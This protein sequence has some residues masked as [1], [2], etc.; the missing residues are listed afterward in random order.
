MQSSLQTIGTVFAGAFASK[1]IVGLVNDVEI[2]NNKIKLVSNSG[3]EFTKKYTE[4]FNIAQR[5]GMSLAEVGNLYTKLDRVQK[6]AGISAEQ[7]GKVTETFS[8]LLRVSGVNAAGASSALLQ[9][10]QAMQSGRL[11]GDEFRTIVEQTPILLTKM[12]DA[13]GITVGQLRQLSRDQKLT[14]DV[15]SKAMLF[16]QDDVAGLANKMNFTLSQAMQRVGNAAQDVAKNFLESSQVINQVNKVADFLIANMENI[17]NVLIVAGAALVGLT[18]V[19]SPLLV[20]FAGAT[21]AAIYFADI[22]GPFAKKAIDLFMS[23]LKAVGSVLAGLGAAFKAIVDMRFGDVFTDYGKAVDDYKNRVDPTTKSQSQLNAEIQAS[24][25]GSGMDEDAKAALGEELK[26]LGQ[27]LTATKSEYDKFNAKIDESVALSGM[28]EKEKKKQALIYDGLNAKA[29]DLGVA[30]SELSQDV[31]AAI[32]V[33]IGAKADLIA[34]NEE[35]L[36]SRQRL[37]DEALNILN[38][39]TDAAKKQYEDNLSMT[40]LYLRDSQEL[41]NAAAVLRQNSAGKSAE[42]LAKIEQD[43]QMAKQGLQMRGLEELSKQYKKYVDDTKTDV[44]KFNEELMLLDEARQIAG[45]EGEGKYQ[46]ALTGLREKYSK[47][48]TD[49]AKDFRDSELSATEKYNKTITEI[50]EANNAGLIKSQEDYIAVRMKAEKDYREATVREYSNL[51]GL[52]EEKIIEFSGL[53]KKEFGILEETVQLVFGVNINDIIKQAFAEFIKYVI[54]FRSAADGEMNLFQGIMSKIFGKGGTASKEVGVFKEEGTGILQSMSS[55]FGDIFGGLIDILKSVFG[56]GLGIIGEF[57]SGAFNL[58]KGFGSGIGDFFGN[59][60]SGFSGG[61][62]FGSIGD[63]FSG[64]IFGSIGSFIKDIPVIGDIASGIGN[65]FS[66]GGAAS[67]GSAL[68]TI[69]TLGTSLAQ[70]GLLVEGMNMIDDFVYG[71]RR[72]E[73]AKRTAAGQATNVRRDVAGDVSEALRQNNI[74]IGTLPSTDPS[75]FLVQLFDSSAGY[76]Q[77]LGGPR[78]IDKAGIKSLYPG[79]NDQQALNLYIASGSTQFGAKGLAFSGG[80]IAKYAKGGLIN[81]PTMFGTTSGLAIGGEAGTEAIMPL[82]RT[83][84]G[85]LGVKMAGGGAVNVNF[86]INAVDATGIEELLINKRQL[87]T[88]MVRAALN[89]RGR[90]FA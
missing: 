36:A 76:R 5:T 22:L 2:L 13:L 39:Y 14:A 25:T 45:L 7:V 33:E 65:I 80:A 31:R 29:K 56:Q 15:V 20:A 57:V 51:Y 50:E 35:E 41:E 71:G 47:K 69:S 86:T 37:Y 30:V 38:K 4:V 84:D 43:Y 54:G 10:S 82:E 66:G 73:M 89:E 34:K 28:D 9:F 88:N 32:E 18:A 11:S 77:N 62:I 44:E 87:I 90:S 74:G 19:F 78:A 70:V 53:N 49:M 64:D 79:V 63:F 55:G 59:I 67:S 21:A 40:D 16:M 24:A 60:F 27:S 23:G 48:W 83:A 85:D 46:E 52:L 58:L 75:K 1:S 17:S 3:V 42:E 68:S 12:A 81:R 26:A 6:E 8:N 72:K 61:D